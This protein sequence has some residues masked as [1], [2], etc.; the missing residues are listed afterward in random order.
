[1]TT[2]CNILA[3]ALFLKKIRLHFNQHLCWQAAGYYYIQH[4]LPVSALRLKVKVELCNPEEATSPPEAS[5]ERLA[6]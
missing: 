1:L 5:A 6:R 3:S 2:R 4:P